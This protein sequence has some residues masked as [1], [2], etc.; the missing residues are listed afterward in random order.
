LPSQAGW[1][2]AHRRGSHVVVAGL[3]TSVVVQVCAT[4]SLS[5]SAL[6]SRTTD[7]SHR[8]VPGEHTPVTHVPARQL[9]PVSAQFVDVSTRRPS[10]EQLT[11]TLPLHSVCP[12]VHTQFS[13]EAAPAPST[14]VERA[15]QGDGARNAFPSAEQRT[16]A[17]SRQM[18]LPASQTSLTHAP[19][20]QNSLAGQSLL[21]THATQ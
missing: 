19:S 4:L 1:P 12:A 7:P 11:L 17:L 18:L 5:P 15:L 14:H 20:T 2:G 10:V 3:Q 16:T 21:A 9:R 6:Q 8:R 13:Q